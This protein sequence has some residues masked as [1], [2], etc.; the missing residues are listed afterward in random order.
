[1]L[2]TLSLAF[3]VYFWILIRLAQ[4]Y[5]LFSAAKFVIHNLILGEGLVWCES[6]LSAEG[7]GPDQLLISSIMVKSAVQLV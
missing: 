5:N 1:M 7:Q 4:V 2:L 6:G 3:P